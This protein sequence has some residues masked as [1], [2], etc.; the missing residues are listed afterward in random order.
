MRIAVCGSVALFSAFL[1]VPA[2]AQP[3]AAAP[4]PPPPGAAPPPPGYP[5]PGA[6]YPQAPPQ[7]QERT[8]LNSL[9]VEGLGPA[10][11]YS[12][13]YD[14]IISDVSLRVGIS[15]FSLSASNASGDSAKAYW[16]AMPFDVNYIGLGSKKHIFEVGGGGTVLAV[17]AGTSSLG[18]ESSESKVF[19]FGHLNLG[20]RLQPPQGGFML[21]TGISPIIGQGLGFLPWPYIGLGAT[22]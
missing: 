3:P 17:G 6:Y 10:I 15:Y 7:N 4:G 1:A 12:F 9:Y 8:A 13:N 19:F 22:F 14:R 5:P 16:L 20:Y 2:L 21:R 18:V 11:F